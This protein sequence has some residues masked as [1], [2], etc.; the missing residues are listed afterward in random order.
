MRDTARA[1]VATGAV[2]VYGV[3]ET[4]IG[5]AFAPLGQPWLIAAPGAT[6]LRWLAHD[7]DV[8]AAVREQMATAHDL[9]LLEAA[10]WG[11][12]GTA[13]VGAATVTLP[14]IGTIGSATVV[15]AIGAMML[16]A[17][18][19]AAAIAEGR[20]PRATPTAPLT[21]WGRV[22]FEPFMWLLAAGWG[23]AF[24]EAAT[25]GSASASIRNA[26]GRVGEPMDEDDSLFAPMV[27]WPRNRDVPLSRELD[28]DGVSSVATYQRAYLAAVR[29][30]YADDPTADLRPWIFTQ[31][32]S[33][34]RYAGRRLQEAASLIGSGQPGNVQRWIVHLRAVIM[35]L[36]AWQASS[37][38]M[39]AG[40][41]NVDGA[42]S[43][44]TVER[45]LS[46][47]AALT[48]LPIVNVDSG[49][50]NVDEGG[51]GGA[52]AAAAAVVVGLI[53]ILK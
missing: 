19:V 49:G 12:A 26:A 38:P 22:V 42:W 29:A 5:I 39:N 17:A 6:V 37:L 27:Q 43:R 1:L 7:C 48:N 50:G 13:V 47:R 2:E 40:G 30:A 51:G 44:D 35:T 53:A 46:Q 20:A 16:A 9:L 8:T 31:A 23:A 52:L 24:G 28:G 14:I 18:E 21:S 4:S 11:I 45:L 3:I 25:T 41:L 15:A 32:A 33:D 10:V 34:I 36:Q